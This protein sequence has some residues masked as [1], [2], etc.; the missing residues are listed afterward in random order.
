MLEKGGKGFSL[1]FSVCHDGVADFTILQLQKVFILAGSV[2]GTN[3]CSCVFLAVLLKEVPWRL[4][5]EVDSTGECQR[6]NDLES[7]GKS[8]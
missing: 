3:C 1:S 8:P 5:E 6:G 4:G 2:E 7:K